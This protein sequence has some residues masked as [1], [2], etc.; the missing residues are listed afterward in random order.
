MTAPLQELNNLQIAAIFGEAQA[1]F[2]L[3]T[4]QKQSKGGE[5]FLNL[6]LLF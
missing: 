4:S 6:F 3:R 5:H 2:G 1:E